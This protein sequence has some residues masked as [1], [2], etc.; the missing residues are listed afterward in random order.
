VIRI[1]NDAGVPCGRSIGSTRPSPIPRYDHLEMAQ[2]PCH[3]PGLGDLTIL[4]H[5]GL[6]RGETPADPHR[7]SGAW[8][9]TTRRSSISIGYTKEQIADLRAPRCHLTRVSHDGHLRGSA[10]SA[11]KNAA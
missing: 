7:G 6:A 2:N 11:R 3:S 4:G 9:R 1:L 5:P 8:V 10:G